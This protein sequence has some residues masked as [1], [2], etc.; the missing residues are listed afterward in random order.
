M[1][2]VRILAVLGCD[3]VTPFD[4]VTR[5]DAVTVIHRFVDKGP[6]DQRVPVVVVLG[7]ASDVQPGV[8][9]NAV[10]FRER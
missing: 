9:R 1:R 10:T 2:Q 5:C 4:A 8:G 6:L 7:F 3:A